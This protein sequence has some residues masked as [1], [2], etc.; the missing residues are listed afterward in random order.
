MAGFDLTTHNS[1]LL[2]GRWRQCNY[3]GLAARADGSQARWLIFFNVILQVV[4]DEQRRLELIKK[5]GKELTSIMHVIVFN[6][7]SRWPFLSILTF[8]TI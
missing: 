5:N 1:N 8:R 4:R 2:G 7:T 3:V 6:T